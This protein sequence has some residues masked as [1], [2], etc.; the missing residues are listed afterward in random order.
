MG[1]FQ[2]VYLSWQCGQIILLALP[3]HCPPHC[4]ALPSITIAHSQIICEFASF[5]AEFIS[6]ASSVAEFILLRHGAN[7]RNPLLALPAHCPPHC[8]AL[9]SITIAHSQVI[10][11]FASFVAEF[12][13]LA[14]SVAEFILLR[15]GAN[16]RNPPRAAAMQPPAAEGARRR[17]R[18]PF[19]RVRERDYR[20]LIPPP[21]SSSL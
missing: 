14:S 12:I 10:C 9:P 13:S 18:P 7:P 6:L 8:T 5:V 17:T 21:P 2:H 19:L 11:E 1:G 20:P 16:P 15:H 4:T 3:A